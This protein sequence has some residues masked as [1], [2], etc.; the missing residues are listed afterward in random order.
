V[1]SILVGVLAAGAQTIPI[2]MLSDIHLDPFHDP[3][4]V[5]QL[6]VA[7]VE[8][9][10]A[11]LDTPDSATQAADFAKLE[12]ACKTRSVDTPWDLLKNSLAEAARREAKPNFVTVS[13]DLMAHQ[14]DCR[15]HTLVQGDEAAYSR[16]AAKTVAFVTLK[17]RQTFPGVPV[18]IAL[19]NNDSGCGDYHEDSGSA[20]LQADGV[21]FGDAVLDKKNRASIVKDFSAEGDYSVMLPK[22]MAHTRLIALQDIF[23]AS[24]FSACPNSKAMANVKPAEAQIGWLRTQLTEA[25]KR[26]EHVWLLAHMPPG[27]DAYS[28][29]SH[30][31]DICGGAKPTTFLNNEELA[32]TITG[33]ADVITLVLLGHTHMDEMRLYRAASGRMVPGKLTPSITPVVG[34]KPSFIVANI[35]PGAAMMTD[36]TV[37]VS[38]DDA[39]TSWHEEYNYAKT[40]GEPDFSAASVDKLMHALSSDEA[41]ARA[42][43]NNY[44]TGDTGIHAMALTMAWP[45][46]VCSVKEATAAE[47]HD[48]V[49]P[50][51]P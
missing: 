15:F 32:T 7:P 9:W 11:I 30:G 4:K 18:Y 46:Y 40:Y 21:S 16:F 12:T 25:R 38:A 28:T 19:G 3:G 45:G 35:N 34:N 24:R 29:F 1:A 13:G 49:C 14:F 48:C 43:Q 23:E 50:A 22:P 2:V 20:F 5:A 51:K 44:F 42:Y 37:Y 39:G 17:L 36:Y 41:I 31:A 10:Q 27:V 47:F 33:Y 26:H 6:N 8:G